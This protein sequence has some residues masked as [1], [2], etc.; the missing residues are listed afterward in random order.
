MRR[1]VR[2]VG[3]HLEDEV[4]L[5]LKGPPK[6]G[7]IRGAESELLCPSQDVDARVRRHD[8]IDDLPRSVGRSV[9]DR[10]DLESGSWANTVSVSRAMFSRSLYVGTM[11][12]ARSALVCPRNPGPLGA[13]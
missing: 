7:D 1:V 4:I 9:V 3:V 11:T 12:S 5:S 8:S 10:Q 6:A 2:K 13:R